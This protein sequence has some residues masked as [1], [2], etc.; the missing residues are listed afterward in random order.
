MYS[1]TKS[2]AH[3]VVFGWVAFL[4]LAVSVIFGGGGSHAAIGNLVVLAFGL[5]AVCW[6]AFRGEGLAAKYG[7]WF[8]ILIGLTVAVPLLHLIPLPPALWQNL[9]GRDL[10]VEARAFAGASDGWFALTVDRARTLG[11]LVAL[12]VP[13]AMLLSLDLRSSSRRRAL[14]MAIV[15]LGAVHFLLGGLQVILGDISVF[16]Y[17]SRASG[18]LYG[19]FANHNSAGLFFVLSLCALAGVSR[20]EF[21]A[22]RKWLVWSAGIV[23][24]LG[25]VLTQSRSSLAIMGLVLLVLAGVAAV[26]ARRSAKEGGR[27]R[28]SQRK[29]VVLLAALGALL[30]A[31]FLATNART[32]QT[33]ERFET[34]EDSRPEIWADTTVA[35]ERYWP[36]GSGMSTFDEVFQID[37]SLETLI[38][39]KAGRAHNDY[40]E[41][42]LEAGIFGALMVLAWLVWLAISAWRIRGTKDAQVT[43][44][45]ALALGC[46]ALQSLIDYPLRNLAMLCLAASF[47]AVLA[48]AQ[49]TSRGLNRG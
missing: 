47:A 2:L 4:T 14:L 5:L 32:V 38:A 26:R 39:A 20:G 40:L 43:S 12:A 25:C 13:L 11:A 18:R 45:S 23:F 31:A 29:K 19:L 8:T 35:I 41:I 21:F 10:A 36:M 30:A 22:R 17:N 9:P 6:Y 24:V 49:N 33:W 42:V 37:E 48:A 3:R 7:W 27:R 1:R 34:L 28:R 46:I 44:F 15:G 16:G